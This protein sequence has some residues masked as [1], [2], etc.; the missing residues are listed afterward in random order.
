MISPVTSAHLPITSL[1]PT[2]LLASTGL[3]LALPFVPFLHLTMPTQPTAH[4]TPPH[5]K[6]QYCCYLLLTLADFIPITPFTV[7]FLS[8]VPFI[9][10]S[11]LLALRS[12]HLFLTLLPHQSLPC[13]ASL[14]LAPALTYFPSLPLPSAPPHLTVLLHLLHSCPIVTFLLWSHSLSILHHPHS[15]LLLSVFPSPSFS[16]CY[17]VGDFL[18]LPACSDLSICCLLLPHFLLATQFAPYP[19]YL[20]FLFP[21]LLAFAFQKPR[22]FLRSPWHIMLCCHLLLCLSFCLFLLLHLAF[23][24]SSCPVCRLLPLLPIPHLLPIF[25]FACHHPPLSPNFLPPLTTAASSC[26]SLY[27]AL[28][29]SPHWLIPTNTATHC[30]PSPMLLM[31]TLIFYLHPLIFCFLCC[32]CP[33]HCL[34]SQ[35]YSHSALLGYFQCSF[36]LHKNGLPLPPF[37]SQYNPFFLL[38]LLLAFTTSLSSCSHL[39]PLPSL[40]MP[41]LASFACKHI[42]PMTSQHCASGL[43]FWH[44]LA[45]HHHFPVLLLFALTTSWLSAHFSCGTVGHLSL[46]SLLLLPA[47]NLHIAPHLQPVLRVSFQA[48]VCRL[49]SPVLLLHMLPAFSVLPRSYA[50]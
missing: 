2:V 17:Y 45:A 19:R 34:S 49:A 50:Y 15:T 26:Y 7:F 12:P 35:F 13:S 27:P 6:P 37:L 38:H 4:D 33:S 31:P 24:V 43:C 47:L 9:L 36:C 46:S 39:I 16:L 3:P 10:S 42:L 11:L 21:L 20:Y 22:T 23:P 41:P 14:S 1:Q 44:F 5:V 40:L 32:I 25:S 8:S 30:L 28:L 29:I 18:L 48:S